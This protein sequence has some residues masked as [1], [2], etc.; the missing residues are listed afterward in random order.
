MND[1]VSM[2][3]FILTDTI[4]D[5]LYRRIYFILAYL[6]HNQSSLVHVF[7]FIRP[8]TDNQLFDCMTFVW[9]SKLLSCGCFFKAKT[10]PLL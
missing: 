1:I 3:E 9:R 7:M 8:T 4:T 10:V 5:K 2:E 6:I